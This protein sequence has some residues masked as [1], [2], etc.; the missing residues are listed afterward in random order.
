MKKKS[1]D[2]KYADLAASSRKVRFMATAVM[3]PTISGV[4][5]SLTIPPYARK[6]STSVK[7]YSYKVNDAYQS[8]IGSRGHK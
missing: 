2:K 7:A 4:R 1:I 6:S 5:R 8:P 3:E